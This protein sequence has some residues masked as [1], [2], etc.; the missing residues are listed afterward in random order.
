MP[1]GDVVLSVRDLALDGVFHD[2]SF[3]LAPG[4]ILGIA[5]LVGC[6][7]HQRGGDDLRRDSG[8]RG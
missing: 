5:G 3:D 8:H 1:I 2:V 6:G 7:P 4:E